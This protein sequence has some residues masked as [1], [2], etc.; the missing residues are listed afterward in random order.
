MFLLRVKSFILDN[1]RSIN[2]GVV[3]DL[4]DPGQK[5]RESRVQLLVFSNTH[6]V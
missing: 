5:T 3:M 4:K 1:E 6:T 2:T